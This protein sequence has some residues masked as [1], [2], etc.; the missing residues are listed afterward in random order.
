MRSVA[1]SSLCSSRS[2]RRWKTDRVRRLQAATAARTSGLAR[3]LATRRFRCRTFSSSRAV[4]RSSNSCARVMS[5][6]SSSKAR[7]IVGVLVASR[8]GQTHADAADSK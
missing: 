8:R 4:T 5:A 3:P 6:A 1:S 7:T 2:Y